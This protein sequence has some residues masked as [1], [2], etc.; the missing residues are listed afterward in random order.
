[1]GSVG[2]SSKKLERG[3]ARRAGYVEEVL[4]MEHRQKLYSNFVVHGELKSAASELQLAHALRALFLRY[5]ILAT[6]IIPE[7]WN[8]KETYYTSEAFYNKPGLAED[9]VSVVDQLKLEDVIM[10]KQPEHSKFYNEIL[11][12]WEHDGF[13]YGDDLSVVVSQYTFSCWDPTKPHFRLVLL[14]S[15]DDKK[16]ARGFKDILYITNHVTS[17]GTSGAN[18][19]EDLSIELGKF[20]GTNLQQL[21]YL[22]HYGRDYE[23]LPKL[24]D[25]IEEKVSYGVN[26]SFIA[27]F[28]LSQMGKKFLTKKWDQ[29]ITRP[30]DASP[31]S[32]MAHIIKIDPTGM[33]KMRA[34]VKDKLHGKATL[35]PFM[36]AC[37]FV[38][39]YEAGLF[40]DRKW[41][42]FFINMAVPMNT[43]QYLPEDP[44]VRDRFRYG[45]VVGGTNFNFLISSFNITSNQQF[46]DLTE[47]YQQWF[48]KTREEGLATKTFGTLFADFVSKSNNLDKLIKQDMMHQRRAFALL[49]NVGYR[50]QKA[51]ESNPFQLQDLI[52]SQAACEMPFVFSLCCVSTDIGGMSLTLTCCEESI[53]QQQ[54]HKICQVFEKNLTTL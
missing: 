48:T 10:N 44:E 40:D 4:L 32:H 43:R 53:S 2:L 38:S 46:W 14:P 28:L 42:E 52:F 9:Y 7:Y 15:A 5:P 3:H 8:E 31:A 29:P 12:Q 18:L 1:M 21:E 54:W 26:P 19:L 23:Q 51:Q 27:S 33:Q 16:G 20:S 17:D 13:K 35:T 22:L 25:P 11:N 39:C 50:P 30:I 47:Y 6:T 36:Q 45:T 49:S 34:R 24:P 41:N 37:W